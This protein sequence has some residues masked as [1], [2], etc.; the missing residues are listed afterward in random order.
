MKILLL[1]DRME[2]GGVETHIAELARGL[3]RKGCEVLLASGGGRVAEQLADEGIRQIPLPALTHAP[4]KLFYAAHLLRRLVR[5]E[6]IDVLHA[7][8]RMTAQLLR[9]CFGLGVVR[10]VTVHAHFRTD[11]LYGKCSYWGTRTIA[12][13]EDLRAYVCDSYRL[14]AEQVK[15]IPNGIDCTRFAPAEETEEHPPRILFASRLDHDCARGAELLCAIAPML[16]RRM[17]E[18]SICIAG[19]GNAYGHLKCL[20]DMANRR[21]GRCAI[22][23]YGHVRDMAT[24]M[25]SC[26]VFVGVSRAAMEAAACRC[27]V[28]LCGDEGYG[29]I[30]SGE[31]VKEAALTNF[32]A[33]GT[34]PAA[35][36]ALLRDLQRLLQDSLF[37]LRV[38]GEGFAWIRAHAGAECMCR[39]TLAFYR[40]AIPAKRNARV[41]VAGYFGC[42]NLGDDAILTGLLTAFRVWEEPPAVTVLSG[43]PRRDRHRF[44]VK[45][46]GRKNP[47]AVLYVL[48]RSR[49]LILG[50]GSLLQ[51]T[52]GGLSLSYYLMLL[53]MARLL[54]CRTVSVGVGIGPLIGT[55]AKR[56]TARVL[57]ACSY[58]GLRDRASYRLL[59]ELGV[60]S[61]LL[62]RGGDFA[63]LMPPPPWQRMAHLRQEAGLDPNTRVLCVALHGGGFW[64]R[65]VSGIAVYCRKYHLLPVFLSFDREEDSETAERAARLCGG[66][67]AG[68]RE[69]SDAAA[70]LRLADAAVCMRLHALILAAAVSTPALAVLPDARD[71]K[72][73]S[74]ARAV[75]FPCIA[76]EDVGAASLVTSLRELSQ[77]PQ[78]QAF[79]QDSC[80][81]MR[82]KAQKDLANIA[83]MIYNNSSNH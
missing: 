11:G 28:I 14:P 16:C 5:R 43:R 65:L 67:C 20:S 33:R 40:E 60:P 55:H 48:F 18:L 77:M 15:V 54:G 62:H 32:C 70:W 30:L 63:L 6:K 3:L 71:T 81:K 1:A 82:K 44:G 34:E 57:S 8:T 53:R 49:V 24:L 75:H 23:L 45:C 10:I 72:L 2:A 17:P 4:R 68:L 50:G 21:I 59:S 12:V 58:I 64:E 41:A 47:F 37:R 66:I 42:G 79:L 46:V 38:A 78:G 29:G 25:R 7:H 26:D 9:V 73:S 39:D 35:E 51:N 31:T 80:A 61:R 52:T 74:F 83:K 13:S 22:E 56:R 69:P 36:Q 76:G 19:G 27:A